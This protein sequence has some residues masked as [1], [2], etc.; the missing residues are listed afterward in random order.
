[1]GTGSTNCCAL[2]NL[3]SFAVNLDIYIYLEIPLRLAAS[4]AILYMCNLCHKFDPYRS[5]L[6]LEKEELVN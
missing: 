6:T 4:C 5:L 3:V 2:S 1:M